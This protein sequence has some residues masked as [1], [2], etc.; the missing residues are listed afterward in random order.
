MER[1]DQVEAS[2]NYLADD[3]RKPVTYLY[4]PPEGTPSQP[5]N[6][7]KR[8]IT[9]RNGRAI[10]EQLSLDR[11]GFI[12]TNHDSAV[13]NFYD[14]DEVRRVYYPEM[15]SLVKRLTGAA[16]VVAFDHNLRCRPKAKQGEKGV[17]AP[18]KFAHNDY[19]VKSGPQ[20][21]RDLLPE[22]ADDLLKRRFA[23]VNV[24]RPVR[25]P[26]QDTPLA[27][28]DAQSITQQDFIT[29]DLKYQDRIGE[30]YSVRFNPEHRWFYFP[31]MQKNEAMLLKCY[32]SDHSR[33]RFTAHSAFD[34]P[35]CPPDA[36]PR[37][38]I[39]VRTLVFFA[40]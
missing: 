28:C 15:E 39:E 12:L 40:S 7:T 10:A 17:R 2:L 33:T 18:V 25:G 21:V 16:R 27:V 5:G 6:Y 22:E 23:V 19:T 4:E 36:A 9:I 1:I 26:V 8:P 11:Q 35:T 32:D 20:R 30:V 14:E 3:G 24:W 34:D 13:S 31:Q 29:H 37:E 38:S